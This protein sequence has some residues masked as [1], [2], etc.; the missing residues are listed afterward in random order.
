MKSSGKK[1]NKTFRGI[2]ATYN[3]RNAYDAYDY[4]A[5]SPAQKRANMQMKVCNN[6]YRNSYER[7]YVEN[8]AAIKQRIARY[9][10]SS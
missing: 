4:N 3:S 8:E 10:D 6:L 5:N 1:S 7:A 2:P 9:N